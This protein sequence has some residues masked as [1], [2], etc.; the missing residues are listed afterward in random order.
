MSTQIPTV[1]LDIIQNMA[2]QMETDE[3]LESVR[4]R[5]RMRILIRDF[6]HDLYNET[7]AIAQRSRGYMEGAVYVL[8]NV[9]EALE[10]TKENFVHCW[11]NRK[12]WHFT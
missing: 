3:M 5:R 8:Q 2:W 12:E 6:N 11:R 10:E 4:Q 1:I 9:Q 7:M